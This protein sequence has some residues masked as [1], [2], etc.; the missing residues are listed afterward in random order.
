MTQTSASTDSLTHKHEQDEPQTQTGIPPRQ[1]QT[2][3]VAMI[4]T[5]LGGRYVVERA[6]GRGG[7]GHVFQAL[8]RQLGRRVAVKLLHDERND[9][10]ATERF[11]REARSAASLE[12]P[13]ACRLYELGD[14][15][16]QTFL[17]MELLEGELLSERLR[18]GAMTMPEALD[19]LLPLMDAVAALHRA[20]LIHRDLKP[21]N[22][23]LTEQGVKLLDFGL[24][25]HTQPETALTAPS[26]TMAGAV[27]GTLRYMAPEQ[28]TGDPVDE[29]TDVFAL[30]VMFYEMLTGHIP[31]N[32]ETNVDW[33][34]AVLRED[35]QPLNQP[36][37][38]PLE[39]VIRRALQRRSADR[40]TSVSEMSSALSSMVAEE[41]IVSSPA[42]SPS[43]GVQPDTIVVLPF[44][45]L[46][47]DPEVAFLQHGVPEALTAALSSSGMWRV[48]SNRE[49]MRFD[50]AADTVTI[51]RELG[52]GLLVTGTFLRGGSQVR[53]TAQLVSAD[54]GA[55]RWSQTTQHDFADVI[56][57]QDGICRQ[58]MAELP[59]VAGAAANAGPDNPGER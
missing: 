52:A 55:V 11:V 39:P 59:S 4:G 29:R 24:A 7:M 49:A 8:D 37:L 5:E 56:A 45:Q 42:R 30:G 50:E 14:H 28:V 51:G 6:L 26:L 38:E 1:H 20:G 19:V 44:R 15:Q 54:G 27:A 10:S 48:L 32:A 23:F 9:P 58:I 41:P 21:S 46:Q 16:G 31:F 47:A 43:P 34:N 36:G 18:R 17:V 22:V 13:H 57:L 25:R 40:F 35:P 33:L 53:V 3:E 2:T 12:H